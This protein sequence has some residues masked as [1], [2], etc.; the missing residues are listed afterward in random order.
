MPCVTL[1]CQVSLIAV[2]CQIS[3]IICHMSNIKCHMSHVKCQI[4]YVT[5]QISN[6]ICHMSN[7]KCHVFCCKSHW[8][9]AKEICIRQM[10]RRARTAFMVVVNWTKERKPPEWGP[11]NI[12][13]WYS[14]FHL[15]DSDMCL[16]WRVSKVSLDHLN[17]RKEGI[18]FC[19]PLKTNPSLSKNGWAVGF[20]RHELEK[21]LW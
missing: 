14:Q 4:A 2:A 6:V 10:M 13:D 18:K 9:T 11:A 5:C 20:L 17:L 21:G 12:L 1:F 19:I 3:Y 15:Q 16:L 7:V 8:L